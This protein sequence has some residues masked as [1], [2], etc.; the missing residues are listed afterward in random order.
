[1]NPDFKDLL[2]ALNAEKAKFLLIGAYAVAYYSEP[3]YTKDEDL[4]NPEMIYQIG[5]EPNRIGL[6]VQP[7]PFNFNDMWARRTLAN[8]D[9]AELP[10]IHKSDLILLKQF[11]AP[12]KDLMDIKNLK[13]YSK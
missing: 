12:P 7:G 6:L 3:R 13:N 5:I 1:M 2:L 8:Y 10:I 4:K 11:S 9:S